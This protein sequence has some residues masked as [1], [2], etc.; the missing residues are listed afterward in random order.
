M[1]NL[2]VLT[3]QYRAKLMTLKVSKQQVNHPNHGNQ[4][5]YFQNLF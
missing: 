1:F 2:G 4:A 5:W 3:C